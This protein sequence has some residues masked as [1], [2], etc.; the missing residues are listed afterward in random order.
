VSWTPRDI[1]DLTGKVAL[2]TGGNSGIGYWTSLH[3]ASRGAHV[4]LACR[5]QHRAQAAVAELKSAVPNGSFEILP[6]DLASFV[7]VRDA[8]AAFRAKHERLDILCNNAGIAL[9]PMARTADGFESHLAA[10]YLGHFALTGL[11]FDRLATGARV[12]HVGSF[13]HRAGRI[14]FDDLNYGR[15]KYSDWGAYAQSK[16]ANV[17]FM[18][19]LERR[20]R[21]AGIRAISVG[22]HPGMSGTNIATH[23]LPKSALFQKYSEWMQ[24]RVL[25]R[26]EQAA[27]PSLFGATMPGV[28]GGTYFGPSRWFE[29]KGPPAPARVAR[30]ARSEADAARLWDLSERMTGVRFLG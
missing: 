19:E 3:L 17:M 20:F 4:V 13:A 27:G 23:R 5:S 29:I 24:A 9:V 26:P 1:P 6:L 25:N 12:V 16:L 2:V 15:R 22:A 21:R 11:L 18:L 10:N 7:S 14:D 30:A 28:A 8:A